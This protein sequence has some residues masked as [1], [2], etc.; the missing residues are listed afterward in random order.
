MRKKAKGI[1]ILQQQFGEL[2]RN[3]FNILFVVEE[4]SFIESLSAYRALEVMLFR[5]VR[6]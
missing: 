2:T 6:G 1:A 5:S 3:S 4:A